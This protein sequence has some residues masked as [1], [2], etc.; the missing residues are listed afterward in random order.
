MI[1]SVVSYLALCLL[2][3]AAAPGLVERMPPALGARL[4]GFGLVAMAGAG[5]FVLSSAAFVWLAQRPRIARLG[6]WSPTKLRASDPIPPSVGVACVVVVCCCVAA[7]AV[8]LTR[9]LRSLGRVQAAVDRCGRGSRRVLVI[10]DSRVEAFTMPGR[11]GGRIVV[12]S[13]LLDAL[14]SPERRA[15]FAH[16]RSHGRHGHLW[17]ALASDVAVAAN[18]LLRGPGR[19]MSHAIERWADEDAAREVGDRR[20]VART[21]ARAA[22][23][24]KHG[25]IVAGELVLHATASN[26][27]ERVRAM[28]APQPRRN[29]VATVALGLMVLAA[30]VAAVIM[31]RS[32]DGLLDTAQAVS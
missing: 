7:A 27:P 30:I 14:S 25:S 6:A 32:A 5:V 26:V 21:L 18:P 8:L 24:R 16:E 20:L 10:R 9:R 12:S 2:F 17:W 22:L 13:G 28:L 23:L 31:Q 11:R 3:A 19:A 1:V 15:V 29:V 4:M